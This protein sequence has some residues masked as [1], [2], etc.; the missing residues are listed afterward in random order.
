MKNKSKTQLTGVVGLPFEDVELGAVGQ[1]VL[2]AELEE[3]SLGPAD[4]FEEREQR[5]SLFALVPALE[6][7]GQDTDL[8]SKHHGEPE[9]TH[10]CG[11][12]E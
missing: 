6:P 7:T 2:Q 9:E 1:G 8:V 4:A 10:L 3:A 12:R 5:N 11:G